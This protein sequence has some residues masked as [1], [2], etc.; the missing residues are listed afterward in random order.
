MSNAAALA[1]FVR[2]LSDLDST[3][4]LMIEDAG[5]IA[6][7]NANPGVSEY[8][9][10]NETQP[11]NSALIDL[12]PS[13]IHDAVKAATGDSPGAT[14]LSRD[15]PDEP[16]T[17]A[18]TDA[19]NQ[20]EVSC[21][22]CAAESPAKQLHSESCYQLK[23]RRLKRTYARYLSAP[24]GE[25][26]TFADGDAQQS[27]LNETSNGPLMNS[28]V[29]VIEDEIVSPHA[30]T[31]VYPSRQ[32]SFLSH[33]ALICE[34]GDKSMSVYSNRIEPIKCS[35]SENATNFVG[36]A[37]KQDNFALQRAKRARLSTG[38]DSLRDG[39]DSFNEADFQCRRSWSSTKRHSATPD[40]CYL[41]TF[42]T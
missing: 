17:L 32:I 20:F 1:A 42:V 40:V 10:M 4:D 14:C 21:A 33:D 26:T 36:S 29:Q 3:F 15:I 34:Q 25:E 7:N 37:V 28:C 24:C 8:C 31:G 5:D 16:L 30:R 18:R 41:E 22:D 38:N 19:G 11:G 9:S 23:R 35:K 13:H 27:N 6:D 12:E 39:M 2:H